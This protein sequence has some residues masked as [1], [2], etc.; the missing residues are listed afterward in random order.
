MGLLIDVSSRRSSR[1]SRALS[2]SFEPALSRPAS[3]EQVVA[4][5]DLE[6]TLVASNVIET[7]LLAKLAEL[8]RGE[9][10]A[11]LLDLVRALPRYL[12]A[13]KRDRGEFLRTFLR[14]YAGTDEA[15]LHRLVAD[16]L[17][18]GLLR[19]AYPQ[20]IRRVRKHRAAGHR[21]VLITGTVD[22]LVTPM[23]TLFDEVV[24]S[25]LHTDNGRY[26]GFLESPPLVGEARAAWLR[27]YAA[28]AGVALDLS[29]GYGDSYSDRPLLE[30]VGNPVAVNPDPRLYRH[31]RSKRWPVA[32]WT[33]HTLRADDAFAE[34]LT[35]PAGAVTGGRS[36]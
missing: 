32:G 18:D 9:W 28:T 30:A 4:V 25:R 20:A 22:V 6:G 21:T 31:A 29:Y 14:R 8:P 24:A 10:P 2:M 11:E 23:A 1:L 36:A 12:A 13:E 27:R 15:G 26:S 35:G 5:F 19:R 3:G 16:R 33:Q 7:Y 34:T 17:G